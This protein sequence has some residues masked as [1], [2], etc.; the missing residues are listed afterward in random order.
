MRGGKRK[1]WIESVSGTFGGMG[2]RVVSAFT[3][4][5][6]VNLLNEYL[7]VADVVAYFLGRRSRLLRD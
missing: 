7:K 5:L 4:A 2:V 1:A 6:V 3:Y